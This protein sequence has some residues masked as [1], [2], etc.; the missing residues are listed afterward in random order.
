MVPRGFAVDYGLLRVLMRAAG[1]STSDF[2][3]L[4]TPQEPL[5]ERAREAADDRESGT[6]LPGDAG[7]TSG[8]KDAG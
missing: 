3:Q 8:L 7:P 5:F 1:M 2:F 6:S 4:R